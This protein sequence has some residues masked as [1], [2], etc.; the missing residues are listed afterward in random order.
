MS[1]IGRREFMAG[2][3]T[4]AAATRVASAGVLVEAA[5]ETTLRE[6]SLVGV[7]AAGLEIVD[8]HAHFFNMFYLPVVGTLTAVGVPEG[9]AKAIHAI[10]KGI[11][12][13]PEGVARLSPEAARERAELVATADEKVD[14]DD[15]VEARDA[16]ARIAPLDVFQS[17]DLLRAIDR[18]EPPV[19]RLLPEGRVRSLFPEERRTRG[20]YGLAGQGDQLVAELRSDP[21]AQR[22]LVRGILDHLNWQT[23]KWMYLMTK[24]ETKIMEKLEKIFPAVSLF[25]HSMMDM[26][27]HYGYEPPYFAVTPPP[28]VPSANDQVSR[29]A[30][31]VEAGNGR[32]VALVAW[33]PFRSDPVAIVKAAIEGKGFKGVKFYPSNGFRPIDNDSETVQPIDPAVVDRN[34]KDLYSY[35]VKNQVPIFAHCAHGDMQAHE[36]FDECANPKWWRKVLEYQVGGKRPFRDLHLCFAHAGGAAEW[37]LP[38]ILDQE[39]AASWAGQVH[40]LCNDPSFPNVYADFGMFTVVLNAQKRDW[41]GARLERLFA[42]S[43]SAGNPMPFADRACY[44]SD[45]SMLY[46]ASDQGRYLHR[47]LEMFERPGLKA[48]AERFF[49]QN[50]KC[51]LRI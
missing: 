26:D 24:P 47:F 48:Y 14:S 4:T 30:R 34:N 7:A 45:W 29:T 32:Y 28:W 49:G 44:G 19:V 50:A 13:D 23:F 10:L 31:L 16:V 35:C 38:P 27:L 46:R 36:G 33:D 41:L 2:A 51:F 12:G 1:R 9:V 11:A 25:V 39:F 37:A 18:L 20:S 21:E 17:P 40:A 42:A 8:L 6:D 43:D 3:V 15:E 22:V 5:R